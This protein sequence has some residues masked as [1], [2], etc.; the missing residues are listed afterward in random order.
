M[1]Q[2]GILIVQCSEAFNGGKTANL[3]AKQQVFTE[4]NDIDL[5]EQLVCLI[6]DCF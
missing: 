6:N 4:G 3:Q 2:I 1:G 5:G